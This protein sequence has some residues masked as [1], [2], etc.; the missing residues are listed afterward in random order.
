MHVR[1]VVGSRDRVFPCMSVSEG[2][3]CV[4]Y[5]F[6]EYDVYNTPLDEFPI[7]MTA[8]VNNRHIEVA[9]IES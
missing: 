4:L 1:F 9:R 2:I 7:S 5:Y 8:L 3:S 6:C